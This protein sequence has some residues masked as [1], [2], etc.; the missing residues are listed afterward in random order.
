MFLNPSISRGLVLESTCE[1][2]LVVVEYL[3]GDVEFERHKCAIAFVELF[4]GCVFEWVYEPVGCFSYCAFF[5]TL[6]V[7]IVVVFGVDEFVCEGAFLL[8]VVKCVVEQDG[9][10][11][12]VVVS[13]FVIVEWGFYDV[14]S[15]VFGYLV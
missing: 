11:G 12:V 5:C 1:Y 8:P 7:H 9:V 10:C 14:E 3:H 15:C 13:H 4:Y 6:I 2:V